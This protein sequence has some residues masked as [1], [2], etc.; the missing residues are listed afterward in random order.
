MIKMH[1]CDK[2]KKDY[3]ETELESILVP[4]YV[5]FLGKSIGMRKYFLCK[6]CFAIL[7]KWL[8]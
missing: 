7:Q 2:C 4:K 3:S 5:S 6:R 8:E 1:N